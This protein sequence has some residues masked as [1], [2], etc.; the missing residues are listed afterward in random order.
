MF[1]SKFELSHLYGH[2][3]HLYRENVVG[4]ALILSL[5]CLEDDE[6]AKDRVL[7]GTHKVGKIESKY[8]L[9]TTYNVFQEH[10][11][12]PKSDCID[13]TISWSFCHPTTG[14]RER[15]KELKT[16][17]CGVTSCCGNHS[18]IGPGGTSLQ[19]HTDGECDANLDFILLFLRKSFESCL[20]N[21]TPHQKEGMNAVRVSLPLDPQEFAQLQGMFMLVAQE[22]AAKVSLPATPLLVGGGG[23]TNG[24]AS[25]SLPGGAVISDEI[26]SCPSPPQSEKEAM[27]KQPQPAMT[28]G[29]LVCDNGIGGN[30]ECLA[31]ILICS[32]VMS[33]TV[34]SPLAREGPRP[35]SLKEEIAIFKKFQR[36]EY[37]FPCGSAP[38]SL[39]PGAPILCRCGQDE[40]ECF[41]IGIHLKV[42]PDKPAGSGLLLH[43]LFQLLE[44]ESICE[45]G[46]QKR[47]SL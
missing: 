45:L 39:L 22:T 46:W 30:Q 20:R 8:V 4:T 42:S 12:N 1:S 31:P 15:G 37:S 2:H 16:H 21:E 38:A 33:Q 35:L 44:G 25:K 24:G 28:F 40:G 34:G 32:P 19:V 6:G 18:F 47:A 9:L 14:E 13:S 26:G 5:E 43:C 10:I 11:T 41:V 7:P 3:I 17:V 29:V 23:V 36:I 27:K